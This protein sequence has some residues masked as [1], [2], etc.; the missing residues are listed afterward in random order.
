M[1]THGT[2]NWHYLAVKSISGLLKKITSR[3]NDDFHCLNCFHSFTTEKKLRKHERIYHDRDF[4]HL[5]MPD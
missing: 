5:K 4:C 3:H 1:I 2:G